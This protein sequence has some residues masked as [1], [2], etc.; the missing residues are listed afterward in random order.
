MVNENRQ[1]INS[2]FKRVLQRLV[3]YGNKTTLNLIRPGPEGIE[4]TGYYANNPHCLTRMVKEWK[5]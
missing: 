1:V 2:Q 4:C 5:I 3:L